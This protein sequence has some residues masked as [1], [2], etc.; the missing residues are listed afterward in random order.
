MTDQPAGGRPAA[1]GSRAASKTSRSTALFAMWTAVSRVAGLVR[2]IAASALFGTQGAI[3]A[4]VIA[5]Q[6]P[7][8][9]RSLVA[10]SALSAAFVPVFTELEE[11][12]RH[13]ESQRL[14]GALLGVT[15][16]VL[17]GVSVLAVLTAPWVMPAIAPG[18]P[19]ALE[20]DL[21]LLS[22]VMFPIVVMLGL[23]GIVVAIQQAAGQFGPSAFAPVLWNVV[24]IVV[25][26]AGAATF[27]G[28][29]R[30]VMY[31]IGILAGTLAQLLYLMPH[32][33]GKGPFRPSLGRGN[34]HLRRVLALMGPVTIGLGLINVNALVGTSISTL[35]SDEAPRAIDAAFR[36]YILP[37]GIFSVAVA[38]VLFPTISRMAARNDIRGVRDAVAAGLRMIVFLLAPATAFLMVLA[39][40]VV[41]VVF[42]RGEFNA[43]STL[44]TS[45]ALFYFTIGLAFNGASLLVIRAFF[46]LQRPGIPTKVALLGTVLNL[47]LDLAL[48]TPFGV[49]GIPLA[50]SITSI[51]TFAVM[52]HLLRRELGG[53]RGGWVMQGTLLACAGAGLA[54]LLAWS[55]F[56]VIDGALGRSLP[57]QFVSVGMALFAATFA[58]LSA[59]LAF[60]MP[61]MKQLARLGRSV[62]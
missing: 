61:E 12:G 24:I 21:V 7:N 11:S 40:P 27:E 3:N 26:V 53:L 55:S 31:A 18:L 6:A 9:L 34:P 59:G 48:Y 38:T 46:S 60:G 22:Q 16:L 8:V 30:V 35:V 57:A 15:T 54:A 14:A 33:R 51:V 42:Q 32:I 62:R 25:M 45:E 44:L 50:T 5:F 41:R 37:Q 1:G 58:F 4:F 19:V 13:K 10:D 20:D 23:T 39:E 47:V 29:D 49:G 36:L 43:D 28:D 56:H 2:E 17:G 52:A